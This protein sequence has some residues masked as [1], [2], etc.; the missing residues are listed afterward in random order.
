MDKVLVGDTHAEQPSQLRRLYSY[1]GITRLSLTDYENQDN[2]EREKRR[3]CERQ[4]GK[5]GHETPPMLPVGLAV[6]VIVVV[7]ITRILSILTNR[8]RVITYNCH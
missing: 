3:C 5:P 1:A 8:N 7:E 2:D 6:P 4:S